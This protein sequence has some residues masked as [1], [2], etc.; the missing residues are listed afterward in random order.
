MLARFHGVSQELEGLLVEIPL[1]LWAFIFCQDC[2]EK[3]AGPDYVC[4][5][6]FSKVIVRAA[7]S[8]GA[9]RV[10]TIEAGGVFKLGLWVT[11]G[12]AE[13]F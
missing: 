6:V 12:K 9:R 8:V 4:E 13:V 10:T 3:V 1:D 2:V 7:R 11:S 5:I